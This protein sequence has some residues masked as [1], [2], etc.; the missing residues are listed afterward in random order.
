MI[1]GRNERN[2]RITLSIF[3]LFTRK[4]RFT[5]SRLLALF[6]HLKSMF[7]WPRFVTTS[8][9]QWQ[10]KKPHFKR[11]VKT[12]FLRVTTLVTTEHDLSKR[13]GTKPWVN[14]RSG[15]KWRN[16][17]NLWPLTLCSLACPLV[18]GIPVLVCRLYAM[19]TLLAGWHWRHIQV[20]HIL[21][22][23]LVCLFFLAQLLVYLHERMKIDAQYYHQFEDRVFNLQQSL[24]FD[25][26]A[27]E[28]V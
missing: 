17:Y 22:T 6:V 12:C 11:A 23:V 24:D 26:F 3:G 2:N 27:V 8:S 18:N 1:E 19:C 28:R 14:M 5:I 9:S 16:S 4:K 21:L 7:Y 15:V 25:G 10:I 20:E 13:K